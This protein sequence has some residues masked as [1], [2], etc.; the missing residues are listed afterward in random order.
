MNTRNTSITTGSVYTVSRLTENIKQLLEKTFPIIWVEGEVS[1]FKVPASGHFYFTLKDSAA[2]ISGV[3]FANQNRLLRFRPEDGMQITGLGRI[4]VY[5][6]RGTYQIIFE[7]MMPKGVG[8]LLVAFEELKKKLAAEGLF[9]EEHKK[10]I[11]FL[12]S[13]IT[14][15]SSA[16]GAVVHDIIN[17]TTRR[18]PGVHIDII[19]VSVQGETAPQEIGTALAL[20][21]QRN[22]ADVI[23]VGR[24]GGSLEDLF[25][26]NTETVARAVFASR[27]PVVSAVGHETD[28]TICDFVA[29]LRAPTPS[30]A[31]ELIVPVKK[32]L[33]YTLRSFRN[34]L[35]SGAGKS[36]LS[37]RTRLNGLTRRLVDPRRK[38]GDARLR[39]DEMALRLSRAFTRDL[40]TRKERLGWQTEKLMDNK[41]G[42]ITDG[43]RTLLQLKKQRLMER[44][45]QLYI[46]DTAIR[47]GSLRQRLEA[48]SPRAVLKRGYSITR[49]APEQSIV[50]RPADVKPGDLLE[51]IV[52]EGTISG[53]V[54][55]STDS[56][57]T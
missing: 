26:F 38:I 29:D 49:K 17:I 43:Y 25:A 1:N 48:I 53:V 41:P 32:D 14:V 24:G 36:I 11:P 12:P 54:K 13:K 22:D 20:A 6:P 42:K 4:G 40:N 35:V 27:I 18:F 15:I 56:M 44:F 46:R 5:A 37:H 45:E 55:A 47:L 50:R 52:A 57:E 19:P 39:L 16:T 34:R 31:A 9:E 8:E 33:L 2:Q 7:H 30:A 21:N 3:M 51:I 28:Y 10:P 23:V